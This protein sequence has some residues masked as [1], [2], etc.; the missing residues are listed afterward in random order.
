[1]RV[2]DRAVEA[3]FHN[4]AGPRSAGRVSAIAVLIQ[5][6]PAPIV[7][8]SGFVPFTKGFVPP[9]R[10]LAAL[11]PSP[12]Y[13]NALSLKIAETIFAMPGGSSGCPEKVE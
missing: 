3:I 10:M 2:L 7:T 5:A 4:R 1:M 13:L 8:E 9:A 11:C 12:H 6:D